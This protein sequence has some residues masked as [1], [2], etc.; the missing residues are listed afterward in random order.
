MVGPYNVVENARD[1]Q[2]I[3]GYCPQFDAV[4]ELMTPFEHLTLYAS[5]RLVPVGQ[6]TNDLIEALLAACDLLKYRDIPSGN[7]S[8]GN[9]RKLS[10]A[11]ALIGAPF[12]MGRMMDSGHQSMQTMDHSQMGHMNHGDAPAHKSSTP[13]FMMCAAC[14]AV[15]AND[16]LP[17]E[18]IELLEIAISLP[19]SILHGEALLPDL[20]PPRA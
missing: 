19:A 6:E 17:L 9:R 10:I 3:I 14:F 4:M 20:P 1:A 7:L 12:G 8:G 5:L 11:I 15:S 18:R 16:G 13:H 2:R